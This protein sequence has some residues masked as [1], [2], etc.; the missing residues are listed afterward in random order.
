MQR[1][2]GGE[3]QTEHFSPIGLVNLSS[4]FALTEPAKKRI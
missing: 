2:A 4:S 3:E 1:A